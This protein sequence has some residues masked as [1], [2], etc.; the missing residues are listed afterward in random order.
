[1]PTFMTLRS[2]RARPIRAQDVKMGAASRPAAPRPSGH[3]NDWSHSRP[4]DRKILS[5]LRKPS[6]AGLKDHLVDTLLAIRDG[7]RIAHLVRATLTHPN[8]WESILSPILIA[9]MDFWRRWRG[10]RVSGWRSP[11]ADVERGDQILIC[12]T[13]PTPRA[14]RF[15]HPVQMRGWA[16]SQGGRSEWDIP[17]APPEN[18]LLPRTPVT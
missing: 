11:G 1:M 16:W 4:I 18:S 10:C 12:R 3:T 15:P 14:R 9:R 8:P 6:R 13:S 2:C 7:P 5:T 17:R